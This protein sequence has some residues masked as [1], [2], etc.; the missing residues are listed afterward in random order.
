[1]SRAVQLQQQF[2][3]LSGRLRDAG[4]LFA[5]SH[6][7]GDRGLA[8]EAFQQAVVTMRSVRIELDGLAESVVAEGG[9]K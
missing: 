7:E 1:V 8:L 6:M 4:D 5:E 2:T 3:E 9:S